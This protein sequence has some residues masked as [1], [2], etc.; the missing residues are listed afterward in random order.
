M[1]IELVIIFFF[2]AAIYASAGF[3]GGS[4][5]LAVMA[6]F[7][8]QQ[9]VMRPTSLMCNIVV[10]LGGT[11]IMWKNG[12]LNFKKIIPLSIASVPLAYFGGLIKLS[13]R[14]FFLL[15]G[16]G[17]VVAALLMFFQKKSILSENKNE[18]DSNLLD[19]DFNDNPL[20]IKD[21]TK[22][23]GFWQS[24]GIG[25]LIG[26]FS[27]MVGIGGGIFLSPVLNL[28]RWDTP[29]NIAATASFFILINSISGLIGQLQKQPHLDWAFT[30]PLL[31]S[32]FVGGQIGS[33]LSVFKLNQ[34]LVRR[35]TAGLVLY[36]GVNILWTHI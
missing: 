27:G 25:G 11:Y 6:L 33:R 2:I 12:Y 32:V 24:M 16:V 31:L 15:L 7:G 20:I 18:K 8:L 17:L 23:K 10:V 28:M 5:Y 3:G 34:I 36:A 26:F 35:V 14:A 1:H 4:S 29:K 13:D 21:L 22:E 30:L 9:N 19:D